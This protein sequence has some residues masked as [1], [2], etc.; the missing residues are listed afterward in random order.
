MFRIITNIGEWQPLY[1]SADAS[2]TVQGFIP[3]R[4][5]GEKDN[6]VAV[7]GK[8][9]MEVIAFHKA[10]AVERPRVIILACDDPV[11]IIALR[12]RLEREMRGIL[13][14]MVQADTLA[15]VSTER[16][17]FVRYCRSL[18][19]FM[20]P[21]H[22]RSSKVTPVGL[23]L[24]ALLLAGVAFFYARY[25]NTVFSARDQQDKKTLL[26]A[27]GRM[28]EAKKAFESAREESLRAQRVYTESQKRLDKVIEDLPHTIK[29]SVAEALKEIQKSSPEE[30]SEKAANT[31]RRVRQNIRRLNDPSAPELQRALLDALRADQSEP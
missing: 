11:I 7:E 26:Q 13:E 28:N 25:T 19:Q 16:T 20:G 29:S 18:D 4:I 21:R 12:E 31:L 1:T 8:V 10:P 30:T 14:R 3:E 5:P 23:A 9:R 22:P 6:W 17:E 27:E 2:S 24:L 15:T